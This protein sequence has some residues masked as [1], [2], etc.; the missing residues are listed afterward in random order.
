MAGER[1]VRL[2]RLYRKDCESWNFGCCN[3]KG[4]FPE[5]AFFVSAAIYSLIPD[6]FFN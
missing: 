2:L 1:G 3:C 4:L 6:I 5:G